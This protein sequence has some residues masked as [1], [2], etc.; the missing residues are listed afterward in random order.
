MIAAVTGDRIMEQYSAW[1]TKEAQSGRQHTKA[2]LNLSMFGPEA[3]PEMKT[4]GAMT[5]GVLE[6]SK[7]CL[8]EYGVVLGANRKRWTRAIDSALVV[9]RL[10]RAH[11][12]SMPNS[13]I[14]ACSNAAADHLSAIK[15]LGVAT[16]PKHHFMLEMAARCLYKHTGRISSIA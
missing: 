8:E 4:M 12:R 9:L 2:T 6:F 14:Q 16:R 7:V 15:A 13:A 3:K 10:I 11:R 1:Y 5:N